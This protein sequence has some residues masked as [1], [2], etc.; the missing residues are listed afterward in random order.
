MLKIWI[1][2]CKNEY[3]NE[4]NQDY[5]VFNL[6]NKN[7]N[8]NIK[9]DIE[10]LWRRF[11]EKTIPS[12]NEDL[13]IIALSIYA[14]DKRIPRRVF[15]DGWTR[16]IDVNIPVL[17]I[18]KWN[19]VKYDLEKTL[20]FLSGD[21]WKFNF[22]S[23]LEKFREN[24]VSKYNLVKNKEFDCVSLFS[25]GLDSFC[26]AVKL[27]EEKKS[28]CFVGFK[29][30]GHLEKRQ[31]QIY[32]I[33][34][35][36]YS[37]SNKEILLFNGTPYAPM[38]DNKKDNKYNIGVESTSRSRSFLFIAGALAIAAIVGDDIPVYI[39][40]NGFIGLNVALTMSRKGTCS[41]RTTHPYFLRE[42]NKIIKAI[43]IT[44]KV[45][46]FYAYRSKGSI[47][48][49]VKSTQ[50]FID[51]AGLTISCSHP[52]LSRYDK[53]TPPLNCG[54]CYPCL[55]RRAS[56]NNAKSCDGNYNT[57]YSI[58]REFINKYNK[59]EG[60]ASDLKAVL[61]SLNR[62]LSLEDK[63]EVKKLVIKTG[64]L[65]NDEVEKLSEVYIESMEQ[66]KIM[67]IEESKND[68]GDILNYTGVEIKNE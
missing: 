3:N 29:E 35:K 53:I 25:G 52:C 33:L 30:Y 40:E 45:E 8:S 49:E 58:S 23:T 22:R 59:I 42:L 19:K 9:T 26:G 57:N 36:N 48:E 61:W 34:E 14:I 66:L 60:R 50:A 27:L 20:G 2:K 51:G 56:M 64:N 18:E 46:N 28:I 16:C 11:G 68:N 63:S 41:T 32:D 4:E 44:N 54:Y 55:I 31:K 65:C 62:Y 39:P 10:N 17:N 15:N 12:I 24:K 37:K 5:I 38:I 7:N 13:I 21:V 67:V 6:S 43:G 47:V 1:N